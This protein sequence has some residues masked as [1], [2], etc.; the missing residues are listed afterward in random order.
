MKIIS[1]VNIAEIRQHERSCRANVTLGSYGMESHCIFN[2]F[3]FYKAV[4][5]ANDISN[6]FLL[7][8]GFASNTHGQTGRLE[9][10][11]PETI[12]DS[13]KSRIR[14]FT[15]SPTK[16]EKYTIDLRQSPQL[17]LILLCVE[18]K[19]GPWIITDGNHRAISQYLSYG[20]LHDVTVY[21]CVH[22]QISKWPYIPTLA[23]NSND[24]PRPILNSNKK[25]TEISTTKS[26]GCIVYILLVGPDI[27][28]LEQ[29]LQ[30][31]TDL[32]VDKIFLSIHAYGKQGIK[33]ISD[34]MLIA[35]KYHAV[36]AD[37]HENEGINEAERYTRIVANN[38]NR[39][40]WIVIADIDEFI[41]FP[42][43][44]TELVRFCDN[45]KFDYIQGLFLDRLCKK[46]TFPELSEKPLWDQFP[47]GTQ[48]TKN[49]CKGNEHKTTL[50]R[51]WVTISNGH[52]YAKNGKSCPKEQCMSIVHHFKWDASV[53]HRCKD[54]IKIYRETGLPWGEERQRFIDYVSR[55]NGLADLSYPNLE[56]YWPAYQRNFWL[57]EQKQSF[58][59]STG[60]DP[61]PLS[62]RR[63]P[64]TDIHQLDKNSF[65]MTNQK[66][67]C[68]VQANTVTNV[69]FELSTGKDSV[70]SI[71]SQLKLS[72]QANW[73][74]IE[75]DVQDA[76]HNLWKT[77]M[78]TMTTCTDNASTN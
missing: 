50:A 78:I 64:G 67:G 73:W 72:F 63:Q 34:V 43:P 65:L 47:I 27:R 15:K 9:D 61:N 31:Y 28:L 21:L 26:K 20:H 13:S 18:A 3:Q 48:L 23:R 75:H 62:P 1:K 4:L 22:P 11:K 12:S 25:I 2:E 16:C 8:C 41:Q 6:L 37:S 17:A 29:N 76:Y 40:D 33:L 70:H 55:R 24:A 45:E 19:D 51:A 39:D 52:H 42:M 66:T 56:T 5:E 10:I 68:S 44:L 49:I 71:C 77:G 54:M 57:P 60:I 69:L 38:C 36:I 14:A 32:G 74:Q 30:Y 46:G 58:P 53:I 7:N 59:Y 35:E